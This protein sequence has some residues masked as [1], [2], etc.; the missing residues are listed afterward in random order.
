MQQVHEPLT[1]YWRVREYA[2]ARSVSEKHVRRLIKAGK[3]KVARFGRLVRI[4][5]EEA[6]K[7]W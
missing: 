1:K 5:D 2:A 3:I 4:P 6:R 7:A